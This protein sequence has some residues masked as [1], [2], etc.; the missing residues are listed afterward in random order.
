M[1]GF[2]RRAAWTAI[3][4]VIS[5]ELV[6]AWVASKTNDASETSSTVVDRKR[7]FFGWDVVL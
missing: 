3:D 2:P 7:N 6:D 5:V 4:D 1:R